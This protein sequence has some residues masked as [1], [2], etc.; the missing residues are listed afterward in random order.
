M[1]PFHFHYLFKIYISIKPFVEPEE[2]GVCC[3]QLLGT[4]IRGP[5]VIILGEMG[6]F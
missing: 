2:S 5:G 3:S 6:V 1:F 4:G